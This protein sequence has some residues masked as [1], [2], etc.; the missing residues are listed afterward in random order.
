MIWRLRDQERCCMFIILM[1]SLSCLLLYFLGEI[2]LLVI[3]WLYPAKSHREQRA[4]SWFYNSSSRS[5]LCILT[6]HPRGRGDQFFTYFHYC[7]L[8]LSFFFDY[9]CLLMF[10]LGLPLRLLCSFPWSNRLLFML[11]ELNKVLSNKWTNKWITKWYN[12]HFHSAFVQKKL[13]GQIFF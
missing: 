9:R 5:L 4:P 1:I 10:P 6:I 12:S 8:S 3:T 7:S 2:C 11:G 13:R